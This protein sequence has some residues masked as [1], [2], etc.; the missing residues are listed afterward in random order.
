MFGRKPLSTH[1]LWLDSTVF[2]WVHWVLFHQ[3]PD[4]IW[5]SWTNLH[6]L[7]IDDHNDKCL[8]E[9]LTSSRSLYYKSHL[10]PFI[11][12]RNRVFF[13]FLWR[14]WSGG[15]PEDGLAKFG[16]K[17]IGKKIKAFFKILGNMLESDSKIWWFCHIF[18]L[19]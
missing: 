3:L 18:F 13:S 11:S 17:K 9:I 19:N 7:W 14:S 8:I 6:R 5:Q 1:V 16:Y 4:G 10:P 12:L 2:H 15:D